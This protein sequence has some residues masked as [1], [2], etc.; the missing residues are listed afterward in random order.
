MNT[1]SF[2]LPREGH[3]AIVVTGGNNDCHIILRGGK[4][5]NYDA[6]S[7][8]ACCEELTKANLN[9]YVMVDASHSNSH[10]QFKLQMDVCKDLAKQISNGNKHIMGVMIESN[11]MEGNQPI[12]DGTNLQYGLS[13]TD[14]C[15]GWEDTEK[16]LDVLAKA[17][18]DRRERDR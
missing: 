18:R 9:P 8:Q 13:I 10:K 14:A 16:A 3:S 2:P 1:F 5:P 17:V 6:Q 15:I 4:Q 12:G 11:L 7:V